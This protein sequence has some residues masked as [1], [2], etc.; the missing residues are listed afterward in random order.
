[1]LSYM[2]NDSDSDEFSASLTP[3]VIEKE[4]EKVARRSLGTVRSISVVKKPSQE[5]PTN[6]TDTATFDF[7][8][9]DDAYES[10]RDM[11]NAFG[12]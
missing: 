8:D 1:M 6:K 3:Q 2:G 7:P 11:F 10:Y 5:E 12:K 9:N 4:K